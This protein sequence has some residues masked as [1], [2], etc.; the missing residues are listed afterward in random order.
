MHKWRRKKSPL[1]TFLLVRAG[2]WW[3][4]R[5]GEFIKI[6]RLRSETINYLIVIFKSSNIRWVVDVFPRIYNKSNIVALC[7]LRWYFLGSIPIS[8]AYL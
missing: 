2:C 6:R 4:Q 8:T 3:K 7:W 5:Y 1:Q